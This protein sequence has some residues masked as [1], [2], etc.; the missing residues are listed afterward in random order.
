MKKTPPAAPA[1]RPSALAAA[2]ADAE[3]GMGTGLAA[4]IYFGLALLY[5][6]PG[7][8]PGRMMSGTDY[9]NAGYFFYDFISQRTADGALPG[10]VPYVYGGMR[11]AAAGTQRR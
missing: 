8:L 9:L 3:P 6:L 2:P 5:F 11:A 1:R 10:W 4:A 7:F